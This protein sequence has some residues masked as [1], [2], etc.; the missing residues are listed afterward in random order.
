MWV[1]TNSLN[2]YPHC[3]A[4]F[5]VVVF[6]IDITIFFMIIHLQ[7]GRICFYRYFLQLLFDVHCSD[8]IH[9]FWIQNMYR[10]NRQAIIKQL[11]TS[12][13]KGIRISKQLTKINLLILILP[14]MLSKFPSCSWIIIIVS[15]HQRTLIPYNL[16]GKNC[17]GKISVTKFRH[18]SSKKKNMKI[19]IYI[20]T[21]VVS[22]LENLFVREIIRPRNY[23]S[24]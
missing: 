1:V 7:M 16:T 14:K 17:S 22:R 3:G 15:S 2:I 20:Y 6:T 24:G 11:L 23:S 12:T 18:F 10:N 8:I 19:E 13:K 21:F 5:A 9:C 4:N